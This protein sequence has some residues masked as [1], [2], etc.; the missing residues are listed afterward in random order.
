MMYMAIIL[1]VNIADPTKNDNTISYGSL[2]EQNQK[3]IK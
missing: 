1:R 2:V 3:V